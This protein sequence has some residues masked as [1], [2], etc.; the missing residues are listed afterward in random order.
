MRVLS[1]GSS[2]VWGRRRHAER[3]GM[4]E[5][6]SNSKGA[7][8][9]PRG[10]CDSSWQAWTINLET[11]LGNNYYYCRPRTPSISQLSKPW[12]PLEGTPSIQ[13][14]CTRIA[15]TVLLF[16]GEIPRNS[17]K[18]PLFHSLL[19]ILGSLS[20]SLCFIRKSPVIPEKS[21]WIHSLISILGSLSLLPLFQGEIPSDSRE[22]PIDP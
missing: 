13:Y 20:L 14:I 1:S 17:G 2:M 18:S 12:N 6:K 3:W 7:Y 22:I 21:P 5:G 15:T 16:Q 4:R 19:P 11:L 9:S 10:C 8:I